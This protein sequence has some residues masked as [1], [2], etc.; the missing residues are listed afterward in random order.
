[1]SREAHVRFDGSGEGQVLPATLLYR[2]EL[3]SIAARIDQHLVRWAMRKFKRLR[4]K[5]QRAWDRINA[6]RQ[7]QPRL[8]AH[9]HLLPPTFSRPA[10]AV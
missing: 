7:R 1:M 3:Y 10:R 2:S 5:P 4:G 8:F 9:W 6:A